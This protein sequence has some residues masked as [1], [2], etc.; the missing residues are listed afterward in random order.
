MEDGVNIKSRVI[1]SL[2]GGFEDEVRI[3]L[4]FFIK[5]FHPSGEDVGRDHEVFPP[6][7]IVYEHFWIVVTHHEIIQV[8]R[9]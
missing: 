7:L 1:L 4:V 8:V 9:Y 6:V 5:F 2:D 3:F